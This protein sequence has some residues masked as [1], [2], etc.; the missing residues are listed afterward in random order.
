M[1]TE[2]EKEGESPVLPPS[3]P[4]PPSTT[5]APDDDGG[6]GGGDDSNGS[7]DDVPVEEHLQH[8]PPEFHIFRPST[9][10]QFDEGED[11]MRA[12]LLRVVEPLGIRSLTIGGNGRGSNYDDE[13]KTLFPRRRFQWICRSCK[14]RDRDEKCQF[15]MRIRFYDSDGEK[16]Y[17][18]VEDFKFPSSSLHLKVAQEVRQKASNAVIKYETE[19]TP[20]K[21]NQLKRYGEQ[22]LPTQTAQNLIRGEFGL[23]VSKTLAKRVMKKGH[24]ARWGK[25]DDEAMLLFYASGLKLREAD[26]E[27]GIPGK[28][29]TKHAESNGVLT[30]WY[31]QMPVE[32]M[33]ARVYG[34]DS[35]YADTTFNAT[36]SPLKTGPTSVVDWGGKVAPSGLYQ[37]REEEI[38]SCREMHAELDLD[39]PGST[40]AT[41]GGPAW[42]PIAKSHGQNH[43]EDTWHNEQNG[44][45]KANKLPKAKKKRFNKLKYD[46]LYSV[47]SPEKL[48][49]LFQELKN[50]VGPSRKQLLRWITRMENGKDR[51]TATYTTR[52]FL[53]SL[54]GAA[55][56]CEVSMSMLKGAGS[57]KSKMRNWTLAQLQHRHRE[58]VGSYTQD[59]KKE[60]EDAIKDKEVFSKYVLGREAKELTH[61]TH[62][63][64]VSKAENEINPFFGVLQ[65]SRNEKIIHMERSTA[66][67]SLGFTVA[68]K[69]VAGT[70][71]TTDGA[72]RLEVTA[73]APGCET[74]KLYPKLQVGMMIKA[75]NGE[76]FSSE[77]DGMALITGVCGHFTLRVDM[78]QSAGTVYKIRDRRS[79]T[80]LE[81]TV[82]I[83]DSEQVSDAADLH[84]VSDFH[85]HTAFFV[86]C[87]FIQRALMEHDRSM[88]DN[89]TMHARWHVKN[90]PLYK[91]VFDNLVDMMRVPGLGDASLPVFL[92]NTSH[93]EPTAVATV[94]AAPLAAATASANGDGDNSDDDDSS[95][96]VT[97]RVKAPSS[98]VARYN[99]ANTLAGRI[100]GLCKEDPK[101]FEMVMPMFQQVYQNSMMLRTNTSDR[102]KLAKMTVAAT[103][104]LLPVVPESAR[105]DRSDDTNLANSNRKSKS[106]DASKGGQ[107]KRR[108]KY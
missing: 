104:E 65:S 22:S 66:E 101:V 14:G 16:P 5:T 36:K 45:K 20:T 44:T 37:V 54:Y 73:I 87:R 27:Y 77:D 107:K 52:F 46:V 60:I 105:T 38:E 24:D 21:E 86:R 43:I 26:S 3:T 80:P 49:E 42:G 68:Y 35:V 85:V 11:K 91:P 1:P 61:V 78:L 95:V 41:D 47:H 81:R 4:P 7:D 83:P 90:S 74:S 89:S 17:L 25:G 23:N 40:L 72:G 33:N 53:C 59:A 12:D 8:L 55:S 31:E 39:C 69:A 76:T 75:V 102:S 13:T 94:A 50:L 84:C 97:L 30:S 28:F 96:E 29:K 15:W 51:R 71:S 6:G 92:A 67:M 34:Q 57:K 103:N 82:F 108:K 32:V 93:S 2:V 18:R 9:G 106:K 99:A 63:Q 58:M 10:H 70:N 100:V 88:A 56:R 19:L 62:L 64:V 98:K 79:S 48:A